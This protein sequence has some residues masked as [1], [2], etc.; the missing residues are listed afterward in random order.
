[1][2]G[3]KGI[4]LSMSPKRFDAN[5]RDIVAALRRAGGSV[6]VLSM[7]GKGCADIAVG[8]RGQNYFLEIKDG[9]KSPSRRV[10]TSDEQ[11]WH[12]QWQGQVAI[13][14]SVEEAYRVLGLV[15]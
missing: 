3:V 7:V 15:E 13:V 9:G 4:T 12:E 14:T 6:L 1:M 8:L 10:L 5:Q 2:A 11:A